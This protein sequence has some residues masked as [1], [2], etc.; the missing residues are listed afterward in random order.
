MLMI[1]GGSNGQWV[2]ARNEAGA[3]LFLKEKQME[4]ERHAA[5]RAR[6]RAF[7]KR[8]R[9]RVRELWQRMR[10]KRNS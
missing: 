6:S 3:K 10:D 5:S 7:W 9:R 8:T 4:A 1:M 2:R